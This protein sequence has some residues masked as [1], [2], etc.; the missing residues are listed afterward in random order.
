M[1]RRRFQ[2]NVNLNQ[3]SIKLPNGVDRTGEELLAQINI[4]AV[5][6]P[7]FKQNLAE[8]PFIRYI[9]YISVHV[10]CASDIT[11]NSMYL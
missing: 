10:M 9:H 3:S 4:S 6:D 2:W 8:D 1:H 7:V 5:L 11:S